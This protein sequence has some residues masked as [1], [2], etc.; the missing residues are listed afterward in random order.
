MKE[1]IIKLSRE[2]VCTAMK[3]RDYA[4]DTVLIGSCDLYNCNILKGVWFNPK[5]NSQI[6]NL[7]F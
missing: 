5:G 7:E 2:K 6:S 1:I 4:N 3:K